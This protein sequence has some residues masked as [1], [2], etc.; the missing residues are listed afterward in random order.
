VKISDLE[1]LY[2][3]KSDY[4]TV[5]FHFLKKTHPLLTLGLVKCVGNHYCLTKKA[6]KELLPEMF[7]VIHETESENIFAEAFEKQD[8]LPV[9]SA[10]P[11]TKD[12]NIINHKDIIPKTLYYNA[13][14]R[15]QIDT[16]TNL[17]DE[18][19]FREVQ[20]R[21]VDSGMRKGFACIFYGAPGTGK[22]ETVYQIAR[23]T[24]RDIFSV[25]ISETKSMWFGESEKLIKSI[26]DKY[27][28]LVKR[29]AI[30]PILLFNE[31]D[32]IFGKRKEALTQSVDQ[33]ENAIQNIILQE[34][35]TLEG[36]LIATTNLTQNLD[37][38]FERRFLYKV[39]FKKPS[40]ETKQAIW[41]TLIVMRYLYC[42]T[43][44]TTD[45]NMAHAHCLLDT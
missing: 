45:D 28:T 24:R 29:S 11:I 19:R 39:E 27:N 43:G 32:A 23:Q 13:Q 4:R 44:Q 1:E 22:T 41:Q 20:Q 2:D 16:L 17:L 21:L 33:T 8:V 38:A 25:N 37:P 9:K 36:I 7:P 30:A 12:K 18:A 34:M 6:L 26:F 35:E 3:A 10:K 5:R 42:R 15:T 31:A 14:E 40:I